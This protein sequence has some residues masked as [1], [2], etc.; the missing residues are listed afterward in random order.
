MDE[1]KKKSKEK[2]GN[3]T[4]ENNTNQADNK[5]KNNRL[6]I[7]GNAISVSIANRIALFVNEETG[8]ICG[9][10]AE[11]TLGIIL[12]ADIPGTNKPG[13]GRDRNPR[14]VR[15]PRL[16][17]ADR[18]LNFH[19]AEIVNCEGKQAEKFQD[20]VG[21]LGASQFFTL[22]KPNIYRKIPKS[23][24]NDG[25]FLGFYLSP[26]SSYKVCLISKND[27]W[28]T[29]FKKYLE[30][31]NKIE[32]GELFKKINEIV[33]P[34]SKVDTDYDI[35]DNLVLIPDYRQGASED[36]N[37]TF[38][39]G[40]LKSYNLSRRRVP[41]I[42]KQRIVSG[43]W[44]NLPI[45]IY[46]WMTADLQR[47]LTA[48]L[49]GDDKS[50]EKFKDVSQLREW[51][52]KKWFDLFNTLSVGFYNLHI[53]GAI[54]GD[55]R[56]ANIMV[57]SSKQGKVLPKNF[58]WIDIGL[59]YE[60]TGMEKNQQGQTS[61]APRPLGGTRTTP[62][63]APERVE[64]REYED[65]DQI[66][67]EM[68]GK[69]FKLTFRF[70]HSTDQEPE[71]LKLRENSKAKIELG[72]LEKG[73]RIQVREFLFVV[74]K[75]NEKD[76]L[77]SKIYEIILERV[78]IDRTDYPETLIDTLGNASISRYRI[79]RQWS[80]ATDIY[81][82]G[83]IILYVLF[84]RG[85]F[86]QEVSSN[87]DTP[88]EQPENKKKETQKKISYDQS[89]REL[90]FMALSKALVSETFLVQVLKELDENGFKDK[91]SLW[92]R[93]VLNTRYINS[94]E[95]VSK[96]ETDHDNISKKISRVME[97]I[98]KFNKHFKYA[99]F[100]VGNMGL[101]VQ[102]IYFCLCCVWRKDDWEKIKGS[103]S[104]PFEPFC[105]NRLKIEKGSKNEGNDENPQG[106]PADKATID[107]QIL[108]DNFANSIVE[109]LS[110]D[111]IVS[112][113]D[114]IESLSGNRKEQIKNQNKELEKKLEEEKQAHETILKKKAELEEIHTKVSKEKESLK[115]SESSKIR[116]L[117]N[118]EEEINKFIDKRDNRKG[119]RFSSSLTKELDNVMNGVLDIVANE[120]PKDKKNRK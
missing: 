4:D 60:V 68:D 63:Y 105:E 118:I 70:R 46:R 82:L 49:G 90:I 104:F 12:Y 114:N 30:E 100:G 21:L 35:L 59:G 89:Q 43:W 29:N 85:L 50:E 3:I 24:E 120:I 65:V 7:P 13:K 69:Q 33:N 62:F 99:L 32:P 58:R 16:L 71:D 112:I 44:F 45:A 87:S 95:K 78:L 28:P 73:D 38:Q 79:F 98:L 26:T 72:E 53:E 27:A 103:I 88:K 102:I 108:T 25:T 55:P 113:T 10:K 41:F 109:N 93:K 40:E 83:N 15:I 51:K 42:Y 107:M 117:K 91:D 20:H 5:N 54:H 115:A 34:K 84:M 61:V 39:E 19:I 23:T 116:A 97:I 57:L 48:C 86:K 110:W 111:D 22:D 77:V 75:V 2:S 96:D 11:G 8:E 64:G 67:L 6:P 66:R 17:G 47:L 31:S 14:A 101:F 37:D 81:G 80:Q 1:K 52:I 74:E 56:P 36:K 18:L 119:L 9:P 106:V 92:Q 94:L 76:I